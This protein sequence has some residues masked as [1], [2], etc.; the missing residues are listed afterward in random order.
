M[1]ENP[2]TRRLAA[3]LA[4][5]ALAMGGCLG[6]SETPR[7]YSLSPMAESLPSTSRSN[8]GPPAVIGIGPVKL[9]DY[10]D[11]SR[12][13]TRAGDHQLRKA[14]YDRWAGSFKNNI[15]NVL[16]E[17]LGALLHTDRIYLFPWRTEVPLDYQVVVEIIRLDSRLGEAAR[18]VARWS[19]L[20][21][22][23]KKLLA[24]ERTSISEPVTGADYAA[25]VASQSRALA[26]LSQEIAKAIH[27]ADKP[28]KK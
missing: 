2:L 3:L 19:V 12:L 24:M 23:E 22:R 20:A 5:G 14:E 17:N 13:I 16:A 1:Q 10:L 18:L 25:V 27:G 7:F 11:D 21:G 28:A 8:P 6:R 15:S 4:L 9:A 26:Q